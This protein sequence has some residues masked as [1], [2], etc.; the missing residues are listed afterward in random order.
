MHKLLNPKT[1]INKLNREIK[2]NQLY[3]HDKKLYQ[4]AQNIR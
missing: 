4:N 3:K 1:Y 2:R